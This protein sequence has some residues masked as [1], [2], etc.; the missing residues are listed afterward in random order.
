MDIIAYKCLEGFHRRFIETDSNPLLINNGLFVNM[1]EH[2]FSGENLIAKIIA[3]DEHWENMLSIKGFGRSVKYHKANAYRQELT[4]AWNTIRKV[5]DTKSEV[6]ISKLMGLFLWDMKEEEF[7]HSYFGVIEKSIK[8]NKLWKNQVV[9]DIFCYYFGFVGGVSKTLAEI[10]NEYNLET[11]RVRQLKEHC[12]DSFE[13]D[14][15]FLKDSII[16]DKL[17]DLF[18]FASYRLDQMSIQTEQANNSECVKFSR[19]FYIKILSIAFNMIL[20]GNIND[21]KTQNKR[22]SKRNI[23]SNLFLQTQQEN[24]KCKIG[25][26]IDFLAV[27]M[28]KNSYYF[29][30]DKEIDISSYSTNA[31][32]DYEIQYYNLIIA[33]ELE[34]ETKLTHSAKA[35]IQRNSLVTQ[36]EM[37]EEALFELGG[38]A[39]ADDILKK[40]IKIHPQKEWTMKTLRASFRGDNF[41]AVGKHGLFGLKNKKDVREEM[42]N[43]TLNEIIYIYM[44]QKDSP[45]HIYELLRYINNLFPRPKSLHA[46]HTILEQNNKG[47]FKK[48]VGGFYG[49]SQKDYK[50]TEFPRV[51]GG[52]GKFLGRIIKESNGISLEDVFKKFNERNILEEIQIEYLLNQMIEINRVSLKDGLYHCYIPTEIPEIEENDNPQEFGEE[53]DVEIDQEELDFEE[54]NQPDVPD[55]FVKDAVAQIKVRRGQ[56]KFRQKLL[57]LYNRT[58]I[59]TGCDVVELLEA[60]HVLPYSIKKDFSLSNGLLLRADIHTLFDLGM[61]A[62]DPES[63]QL[64]VNVALIESSDYGVLNN[65]DIGYRL[66]KLHHAYK[67]CEEGLNW[68]WESFIES[69]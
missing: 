17:E 33:A 52:H 55:E 3:T 68:R 22:S 7:I 21:I 46:V 59:V 67:I 36:P 23:W 48:F 34:L 5:F 54:L 56:P 51:V 42:G 32:S 10:A 8:Q 14:L 61:I 47:Y 50:N 31:L 15:W 11:E 63:M 64:K 44:L 4:I 39:Y 66:T 58:C 24:E 12:I 41:Y 57:K 43:G 60:A 38:F 65:I 62:I 2:N 30:E 13:Q 35:I 40:V 20:I 26:I 1:M 28:H 18:D 27:E 9:S 45:I 19:E 6:E 25:D 49:L 53:I 16:K 29:R 69:E 37:I